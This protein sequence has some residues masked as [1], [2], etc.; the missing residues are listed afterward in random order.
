MSNGPG[1]WKKA[2]IAFSLALNLFF[3]GLLG[4][5]LL[6]GEDESAGP[7]AHARAGYSLHPRVMMRALPEARHEDIRTF[8]ADARKGMGGEWREINRI[9]MGI[10]EALRADPF[11]AQALKTA[12]QREV[13]ARADL[14]KRSN[15]RIAGF[16]ETLSDDERILLADEALKGLEAQRA[17][18]IKRREN[19]EKRGE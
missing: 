8:Y 13:D 14:R 7:P 19:R 5:Q 4:G 6:S 17:Y 1:G 2:L 12:Q 15:E 9:R 11:D 3:V 10:D 16:V 18:W